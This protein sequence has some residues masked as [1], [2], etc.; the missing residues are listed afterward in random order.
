MTAAVLGPLG[1]AM[2]APPADPAVQARLARTVVS[3]DFED[4]SLSK[5][6][7]QLR[8]EHG[9]NIY[10][11]ERALESLGVDFSTPITLQL[12]QVPLETVLDLLLRDASEEYAL[13][14]L[15]LVFAG[16]DLA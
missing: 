12:E 4:V 14:E 1:W 10:V 11:N 13:G 15:H 7:G 5:I 8:A 16:P 9:L 3:V 2:A 6:L